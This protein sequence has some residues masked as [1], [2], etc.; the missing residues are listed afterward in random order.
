MEQFVVSFR[1]AQ[2]F[3]DGLDPI[4]RQGL[5]VDKRAK[6]IVMGSMQ[7]LGFAEES[8]SALRVILGER[9]ELSTAFWGNDSRD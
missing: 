2:Y 8:A 3:V 9:K 6:A 4:A 5:F 1:N 7:P